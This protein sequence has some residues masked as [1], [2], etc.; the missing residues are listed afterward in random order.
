MDRLGSVSTATDVDVVVLTWNDGELLHAA[1]RSAL[2]SEGVTVRVIVV[3]NGSQPRAEI[4][5]DSRVQVL[6]NDMNRG[7]SAG[8]NQGIAAG[9]A[10]LVC[11]LDSDARLHP[12]SLAAM[13]S[14]LRDHVDVGLVSPVF[15]GQVPEASGGLAP[16]VF[17]KGAA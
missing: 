11:V 6:R 17:L 3:D 2:A 5:A 16:T 12:G 10:A 7:V 8:R 15:D 14:V 1:V 4:L 9:N 13:R